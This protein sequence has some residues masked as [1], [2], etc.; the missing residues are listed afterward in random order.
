[1]ADTNV[2][3]NCGQKGTKAFDIGLYRL[4]IRGSGVP[5]TQQE[6]HP[7]AAVALLRTQWKGVA[8]QRPPDVPA[9]C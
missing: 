5:E 2:N 4:R 9:W 3:Q 1:M 8:G 6:A 7:N